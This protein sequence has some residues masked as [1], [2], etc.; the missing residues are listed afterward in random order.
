MSAL[1]G[2]ADELIFELAIIRIRI[3]PE[4]DESMNTRKSCR[5]LTFE[6]RIKT[7]NSVHKVLI[8]ELTI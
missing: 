7:L 6:Y 3:V 8:L 5:A 2:G 1:R 4:S